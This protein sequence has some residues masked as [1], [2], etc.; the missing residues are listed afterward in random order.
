MKP[1]RYS[2]VDILR[3]LA[4]SAVLLYH[5]TALNPAFHHTPFHY[6]ELFPATR[7]FYLGVELFFIISGFVISLSA[8]GR[9]APKFLLA[10]GRR[11]YPAFWVSCTIAALVTL[12][13]TADALRQYVAN[14]TL[15]A[16]Y[17]GEPPIDGVY[18]TLYME[19]RFYL[20]VAAILALG[21]E[22]RLM[23][24]MAAWLAV[25]VINIL[26]PIPRGLGL[27]NLAYAPLFV[28]GTV[29]AQIA[30]RAVKRWHYG[31]LAAAVILSIIYQVRAPLP[32]QQSPAGVAVILLGCH[33]LM[34]AVANRR[35]VAPDWPIL[36]WAGGLSYPIYLLHN[37]V[38]QAILSAL[39]GEGRWKSLALA[40]TAVLVMA[41]LVHGI[42][43]RAF[44]NPRQAIKV[45][46]WLQAF[47]RGGRL[48]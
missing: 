47:S 23:T 8:R 36:L 27:L 17:L 7:Y 39:S 28:A 37:S 14:M 18:W 6:P 29:Y 32:M 33:G 45:P 25:S 12:T 1:E 48:A 42:V 30:A 3:L 21:Q 40:S 16:P 41:W 26:M 43:E 15:F 19:I 2:I 34:W 20:F 5:L 11:L 4:A 38:G 24:F 31:L 9:S 44:W 13:Q 10:R 35:L 22:R 46:L